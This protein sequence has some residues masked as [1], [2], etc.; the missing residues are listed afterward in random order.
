MPFVHQKQWKYVIFSLL[1]AL[2]KT[3]KSKE[4]IK[5]LA[6]KTFG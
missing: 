1:E 5:G 4:D 3:K 6:T 2:K